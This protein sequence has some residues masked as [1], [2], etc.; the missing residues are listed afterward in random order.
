MKRGKK[1]LNLLLVLVILLIA[2]YAATLLEPEYTGEEEAT[3]ETI[4]T[5]NAENVTNISWDYKELLSFTKVGETWVYDEDAAF[6]LDETFIDTMLTNV[7]QIVSTK[8]IEAV[9]NWDQYTLEVPICEI[10]LTTD[11]TTHTIKIGEETALSGERYLSIG[12]GNAYLVDAQILDAFRYG[13]YD[14][15][16]Y[17]QVPQMD[18]ILSLEYIG[19]D[20]YTID[21][22][23]NSGLAYTD[24]YV[25]FHDG[26]PLD[27]ELT[28]RLITYVTGSQWQEC[29]DYHAEDLSQYGLDPGETTIRLRYMADDVE[30]VYTLEIGKAAKNGYYVRIQGSNMVYTISAGIAE[31]LLYTTCTELQPD[32]VLLMDWEQVRSLEITLDGATCRITRQTETV[33]EEEGNEQENVVYQLDGAEVD[34]EDILDALDDLGFSGYATGLI[35][36]RREEIRFVIHREHET[37]PEVTL[38]IYQYDSSSCVVMLNGEA[39]VFVPREDVVSLVEEVNALILNGT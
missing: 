23:E 19:R 3:Y 8:T 34:A 30:Q 2:T 18:Q 5:V 28:E 7:Q 13:L 1:L 22:L 16:A 33:T 9:E 21:Y 31:T 10:T 26:K 17:E 38:A 24:D 20:S 37:F 4:F 12:D 29:V 11:G 35:P 27:T 15:L 6:P 14:V 36:M 25:W 39:T 32:E